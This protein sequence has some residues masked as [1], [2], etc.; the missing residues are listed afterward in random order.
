MG[1]RILDAAIDLGRLQQFLLRRLTFAG[2]LLYALGAAWWLLAAF[3]DLAIVHEALGRGATGAAGVAFGIVLLPLVY[4]VAPLYAVLNWS[5]W[6]PLLF[7]TAGA[8]LLALLGRLLPCGESTR[9][10]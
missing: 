4:A 8:S 5:D 6:M 10:R 9:G 2:L 7:S 3:V 1:R